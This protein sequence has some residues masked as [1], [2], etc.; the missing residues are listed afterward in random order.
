MIFSDTEFYYAYPDDII[1]NIITL[2]DDEVKHIAK[3]M[4][5]SEGDD[6]YITDGEGNIYNSIIKSITKNKIVA[7]YNKIYKQENSLQNIT[8]YIPVLK[9]H[10]R[11]EF[12]LEKCVELGITKFMLFDAAKGYKRGL[13]LD[14]LKKI[15]L[16]AMKQSLRSYKPT[17][18]YINE[19]TNI[20][21]KN[22]NVNVFDQRATQSF[23]DYLSKNKKVVTTEKNNSF[24]FGPESGLT[25]NELDHFKGHTSYKL[26]N[27]RL[28]SETAIITAASLI[29]NSLR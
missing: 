27:N 15:L 8:F 28:R 14:R 29:A 20:I 2:R 1:K 23:F 25:K 13:K 16:A 26:T 11:L 22:L 9:S 24:I 5:H 17:I 7:E 10:D 12:A 19:L 18:T 3:V 6:V 4:R 21:E